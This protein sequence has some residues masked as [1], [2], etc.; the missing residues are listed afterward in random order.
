MNRKWVIGINLYG[1]WA[2]LYGCL[3]VRAGFKMLDI[4]G[5]KLGIIEL[6]DSKAFPFG[7]YYVVTGIFV[8]IRI[9]YR[10]PLVFAFSN[11]FFILLFW[12]LGVMKVLIMFWG[13]LAIF[14]GIIIPLSSFYF[15]TRPKVRDYFNMHGLM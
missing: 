4:L 6:L 8:L 2:I 11:L 12:G 1:L 13:F 7:L 14:M 15:F 3:L 10:G 5:Y 9:T